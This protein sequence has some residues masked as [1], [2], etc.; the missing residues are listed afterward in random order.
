MDWRLTLT[1]WVYG[2]EAFAPDDEHKAFQFRLVL[3]LLLAAAVLALLLLLWL[4]WDKRPALPGLGPTLWCYV[5]ACIG[6]WWWLRGHARHLAW[7]SWL[8]L[9]LT[10]V[11]NLATWTWAVG[12]ELRVLWF[13]LTVCVAY[14]AVGRRAGAVVALVVLVVLWVG[15]PANHTPYRP[16]AMFTL[17][18][19]LVFLAVFFHVFVSRSRTYYARMRDANRQL[20]ELATHDPLTNTLNGRAFRGEAERLLALAGRT[21]GDVAVLFLDLDHFKR[22]NDVHGHAM[23]DRVLKSVAHCLQTQVR[24][25]DVLGRVGGEEFVLL[26]PETDLGGG[27]HVA[28]QLRQAVAALKWETRDGQP[29]SVT[30]SL[31]VTAQRGQA[32][33][34]A[35]LQQQA[36]QAMYAAKAA[37]R[38]RVV[39]FPDVAQAPAE[40]G[41][42]A[43]GIPTIGG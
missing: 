15:N 36:D 33:S 8:A 24:G 22:V 43:Q 38:N 6:G 28:D 42:T 3:W 29:L 12:D 2:T 5:M 10:L 35:I 16:M 7:V 32:L 23:G 40:Q 17:T 14:T 26:L 21:Q 4:A 1:T 41:P 19:V 39:A 20:L 27:L 9:L 11:M 25:C 37:G 18:T 31:G 13:L 34:L 30:A